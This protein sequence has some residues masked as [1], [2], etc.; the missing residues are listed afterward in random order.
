MQ[1]NTA[2]QAIVIAVICAVLILSMS[3]KLA[4]SVATSENSASSQPFSLTNLFENKLDLVGTIAILVAVIL[5]W[6]QQRNELKDKVQRSCQTLSI[7][8][9]DSVK[10]LTERDYGRI[11]YDTTYKERN[12]KVSFTLA[13][14]SVAAF[15]GIVNAGLLTYFD[16]QIQGLLADFYLL[17]KNHN[18]LIEYRGRYEDLFFLYNGGP[19]RIDKWWNKVKNYDIR[20]TLS[21]EKII[22]WARLVEEALKSEKESTKFL[23]KYRTR[24]TKADIN[25][26]IMVSKQ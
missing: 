1:R 25:Q 19:Q 9:R 14:L 18:Q 13:Y 3:I 5:Y 12:F 24:G 23:G 22:D 8:V 2:L 4:S 11:T 21:E 10:A 6:W 15:D 16:P 7:E 26:R 20:L 17:I